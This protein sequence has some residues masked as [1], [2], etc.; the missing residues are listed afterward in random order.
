MDSTEVSL[1]IGVIALIVKSVADHLMKG[2]E[3]ERSVRKIMDTLVADL[4]REHAEC[5]EELAD[6][7]E[8]IRDITPDRD[9]A[10]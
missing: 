5:R 6:L 7:R 2:S 1:A 3:L 4:R 10:E 8:L 9:P